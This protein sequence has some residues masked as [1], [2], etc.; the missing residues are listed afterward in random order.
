MKNILIKNDICMIY[1]F[2][3]ILLKYSPLRCFVPLLPFGAAADVNIDTYEST[4]TL[5]M[6]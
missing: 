6:V 5:K 3:K 2:H 4:N 1:F